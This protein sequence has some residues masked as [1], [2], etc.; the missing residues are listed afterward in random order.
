MWRVFQDENMK[1][2]L[3]QIQAQHVEDT[4][5]LREELNKLKEKVK[6]LEEDT[7][8]KST[9]LHNYDQIKYSEKT[10]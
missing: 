7:K 4:N 5:N 8:V 2:M 1:D 6:K 3:L 9:D 10:L